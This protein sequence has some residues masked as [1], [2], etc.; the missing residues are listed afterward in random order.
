MLKKLILTSCLVAIGALTGCNDDGPFI[1]IVG[2]DSKGKE[3]E[4]K[5]PEDKFQ[6]RFSDIL[7]SASNTSITTLN[8]EAT[9]TG[10]WS[11]NEVEL[12][13]DLQLSGGITAIVG[14]GV[15]SGAS[16]TVSKQNG[17]RHE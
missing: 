3:I 6:D 9:T 8:D 15:G 5:V 16:V 10:K 1:T 2:L 4:M 14:L 17:A 13:I 7:N 12:G 11:L